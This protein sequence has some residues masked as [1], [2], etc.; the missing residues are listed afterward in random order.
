MP[1]IV[2]LG[3]TMAVFTPK[4]PGFL[5][6]EKDY[7]MRIAGAES[8]L[9]IGVCKLG[10]TSG[11]ISRLGDDE[12]GY[13]IRNT[14]RSEGV[15]ISCVDFDQNHSTGIMVKQVLPRSETAVFYYR[16]GSAASCMNRALINED[17]IKKAK[18]LHLTGIT[19]VLSK[20]CRDL[21][22]YV[23]DLARQNHMMISFDPNIRK[24]LWKDR[25]FA[26][27]IKE[28]LL[29]SDIALLGMEEAGI[30]FGTDQTDRVLDI[31]LSKGNVRYVA[32]KNGAHG[33]VTAT[34]EKSC[35]IPPTPCRCIDPVGAGDAFNAAFLCGILE[36]RDIEDCGRMGGVAGALA[37]ENF[38]DTEGY[39]S[40]QRLWAALSGKTEI[41]R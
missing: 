9:A 30:L 3:E 28:L 33:A 40:K 14:I 34:K 4:T 29:A 39:P 35:A 31:L 24:K 1:E 37:T 11:W 41:Y 22:D 26:P 20:S 18:I 36:D 25:D 38:G 17:Y 10:H 13:F 6:Y 12:L 23:F 2:T 8:N 32:L 16:E 27:L 5:R 21:T 15:D 7:E 19:P